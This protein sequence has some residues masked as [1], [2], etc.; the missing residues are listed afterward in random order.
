MVF[1]L[2]RRRESGWARR[3]IEEERTIW[4]EGGRS[5]KV[6]RVISTVS[7][8]RDFSLIVQGVNK[9]EEEEQHTADVGHQREVRGVLHLVLCAGCHCH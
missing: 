9:G 8:H 7:T 5:N 6:Q 4:R 3:K 1:V 2:G